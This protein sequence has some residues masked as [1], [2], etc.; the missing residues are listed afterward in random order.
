MPELERIFKWDGTASIYVE[1]LPITR[2][3]TTWGG[4]LNIFSLRNM[5]LC[6]KNFTTIN[7]VVTKQ[8]RRARYAPLPII[9]KGKT[10]QKLKLS[11]SQWIYLIPSLCVG[12][13][14]GDMVKRR[15][16]QIRPILLQGKSIKMA[17][18]QFMTCCILI[19]VLKNIIKKYA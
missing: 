11:F 3:Q 9:Y 6:I 17:Y 12:L 16:L 7:F 14:I 5:K 15:H 1:K 13:H 10:H 4:G 19:G 18:P 8:T 2:P